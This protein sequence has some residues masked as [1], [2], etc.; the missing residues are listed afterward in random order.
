MRISKASTCS[1]RP[2]RALSS[3]SSSLVMRMMPTAGVCVCEWVRACVCDYVHTCMCSCLVTED[4]IGRFW[5][6]AIANKSCQAMSQ[7]A[8]AMLSPDA[9]GRVE[10]KRQLTG[11]EAHLWYV[12]AVDCETRRCP[13]VSS[14]NISFMHPGSDGSHQECSSGS[15]S[16]AI[17]KAQI[18]KSTLSM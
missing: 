15:M 8:L 7:Y 6:D 16:I 5:N 17:L 10:G 1:S 9:T 18:L 4:E 12:V 3:R 14:V 2:R 11:K 13:N